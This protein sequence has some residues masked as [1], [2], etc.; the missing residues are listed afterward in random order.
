MAKVI[1]DI[2]K[3][4]PQLVG[5]PYKENCY[6]A[7]AFDCYSLVWYIYNYLGIK[8]PKYSIADSTLR[9]I[10]KQIK[11]DAP[12]LWKEIS[13]SDRQFLDVFLF[14]TSFKLHTHIGLVLSKDRFLH[15]TKKLNV[16]IEQTSKSVMLAQLYKVYRCRLL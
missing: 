13:F 7:T 9:E 16:V 5:K 10:N 2:D 3:L 6:D 8:L 4:L 1:S 14:S 15:T 11:D 12:L